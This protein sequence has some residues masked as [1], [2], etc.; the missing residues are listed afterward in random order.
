MYKNIIYSPLASLVFLML[1]SGFFMTFITI[2]LSELNFH[3]SVIGYVHSAFYTGMLVRAV[4]SDKLINRIGHIRAY[5]TFSSIITITIILQAF[6]INIY[7][8]VICRFCAGFSI[9]ASYVIIESWL[10]AQSTKKTKG[11]ILAI[12]MLCLYVAQSISQF[13]LDLLDLGTIEPFLLAAILSSTAVIPASLTYMKAPELYIEHKVDIFKYLKITPLGF[14]GCIVSGLILSAIYSF[15]PIYAQDYN[16]SASK[17]LGITVVGGFILQWPVGKLSDIADRAKVIAFLALLTII[18]CII[19]IIAPSNK[20]IVYSTCFFLGGVTFTLYPVCISYVCDYFE[21]GNVVNVTSALVF[22][23]G[24]GS[25]AGSSTV[26][27]LIESFTS[28][29]I[30]YFIAAT[31]LALGLFAVYIVKKVKKVLKNGHSTF[32]AMPK[33]TPVAGGLDHRA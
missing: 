14:V 8:W 6:S 23:Y 21:E 3:E 26:A 15:F 12:Y 2:K 30:F 31:S 11:R 1:G 20:I 25:I 13:L 5:T 22:A 32:A 24:V 16:L 33:V 10:L 9:S 4:K 27:F 18:A 19:I 28:I 29:V 7:N 17:I